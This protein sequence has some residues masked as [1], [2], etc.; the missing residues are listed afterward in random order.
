MATVT[1]CAAALSF[2]AGINMPA[3][4]VELKSAGALAIG[5]DGILF[6]G[7][8]VGGKIVALDVDDRTAAKSTGALEIKAINEKIGAMLSTPS[9]RTSTSLFRAAAART[10]YL[11]SCAPRRPAN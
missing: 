4:K 10:P 11:S 5:P 6:V 8:S 7:D 1:C 2:A 9:P 3:G